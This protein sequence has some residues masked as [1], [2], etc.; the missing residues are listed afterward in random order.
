MTSRIK[1][2]NVL[3]VIKDVKKRYIQLQNN[4]HKRWK[5][6]CRYCKTRKKVIEID[7]DSLD[8]TTKASTMASAE[9]T[10]WIFSETI[11]RTPKSDTIS[12]AAFISVLSAALR[13]PSS[14]QIITDI[15]GAAV[16]AGVNQVYT[17]TDRYYKNEKGTTILAGIK[18]VVAVYKD[19]NHR[20]LLESGTYIDCAEGYSC[21]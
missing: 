15:A 6:N 13:I 20:D 9:L 10:N 5:N 16:S 17:K 1:S 4:Y 8:K 12:M 3:L 21:E 11:T 14:A 19:K 2:T 18:D 7:Y